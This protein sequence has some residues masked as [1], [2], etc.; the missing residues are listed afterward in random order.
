MRSHTNMK[1]THSMPAS[2]RCHNA[3]VMNIGSGERSLGA[4]CCFGSPHRR[5]S[6]IAVQKQWTAFQIAADYLQDP[7][8]GARTHSAARTAMRRYT[9]GLNEETRIRLI[10]HP[11]YQVRSPN[12]AAQK[13]PCKATELRG[14]PSPLHAAQCAQ[15][16]ALALYTE[17]DGDSDSPA[18]VSTS[19]LS[20]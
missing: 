5:N 13:A 15:H 19:T 17:H 3:G 9:A 16:I 7:A 11:L 2:T 1:R 4:D 18:V 12:M 6:A 8:S 10:S 14:S 20:Q